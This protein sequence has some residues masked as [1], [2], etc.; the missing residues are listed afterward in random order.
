MNY[1]SRLQDIQYF[2][3]RFQFVLLNKQLSGK[4]HFYQLVEITINLIKGP[5]SGLRQ[6][7]TTESLL[8]MMENTYYFMLRALFIL[9]I[10][11]FLS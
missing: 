7:L 4:R 3:L 9:K 8:K 6:F 11:T 1:S 2:D 5:L 10:F